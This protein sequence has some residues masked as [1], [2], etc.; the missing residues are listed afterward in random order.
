MAEKRLLENKLCSKRNVHGVINRKNM[1]SNEDLCREVIVVWLSWKASE[2]EYRECAAQI[3]ATNA[4][5]SGMRQSQ[6]DSAKKSM[7]RVCSGN[8]RALKDLCYD[9]WARWAG[10]EKKNKDFRERVAETEK[11]LQAHKETHKQSMKHILR[12]M[13][14]STDGGLLRSHFAKWAAEYH[15]SMKARQ[16]DEMI[17]Q[18]QSKFALL[19]SRQKGAGYNTAARANRLEEEN[20][21]MHVFMNWR[22]YARLEWVINHYV[23]RI[24]RKKQ[25]LEEVRA[26]F[27]GFANQL[28][29]NITTTPRPSLKEQAHVSALA[30]PE[31]L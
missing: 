28:D 20:M 23:D 26:L 16:F 4:R 18:Q 6:K 21:I 10:E 27:T 22:I 12:H 19:N 9:T 2:R 5:L 3:T 14:G 29:Q 17:R 25:K 30:L 13:A 8:D 1:A 24:D 15:D 7:M 11:R 31:A